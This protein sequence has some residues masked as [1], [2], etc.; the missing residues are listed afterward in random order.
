VSQEESKRKSI[1][2]EA[3]EGRV[4]FLVDIQDFGQHSDLEDEK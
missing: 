3:L 1:L 2:E 4:F